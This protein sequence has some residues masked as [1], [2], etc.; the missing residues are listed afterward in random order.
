MSIQSESH[1]FLRLH[2]EH[3][4]ERHSGVSVNHRI[5]RNARLA[6]RI[7]EC[8]IGD[9]TVF[10][11]EFGRDCDGSQYQRS[12]RLLP[13]SVKAYWAEVN[14]IA[15]WADGPF[16]LLICDPDDL[17][18]PWSRD[19]ALEAFEDGHPHVLYG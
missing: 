16:Q 13:A 12:A 4:Y 15:E 8:D 19:L 9:G 14:R 17:P 2:I 7:A 11:A 10:V 18:E 1:F 3:L 6:Q 5:N